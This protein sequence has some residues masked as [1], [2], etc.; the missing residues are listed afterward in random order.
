MTEKDEK[1]SAAWPQFLVAKRAM[2]DAY[3]RATAHSKDQVVQTH[4][5]VV[6]EASVRDWLESFLPKRYGVTSGFIRAQGLPAPYQSSHFDVI[7]YDQLEAPILW[8]EDNKDKSNSGRT[9]II[10]AEFALAVLEVKSAFNRRTVREAIAKLEELKPLT[11]GF[12]D[13]TY[14]RFLPNQA[15]LSMLFFEL[16]KADQFDIEPLNL[17]RDARF[18][19]AFYNPVILRGE[20]RNSDDTALIQKLVG[21]ETLSPLWPDYGLLHGVAGS[22]SIEVEGHHFSAMLLWADVNFATFA[23]D[24]LALLKG[25]YRAGYGSSFHGLEIRG[26]LPTTPVNKPE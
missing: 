2:L 21:T 22:G 19:R 16:R 25:T 18:R 15:I 10:P 3:D 5:G 8:I 12:N 11:S 9:R 17:I 7:I 24:P 1:Y 14:P 20:G 4:H 23:F 13:G 6:G 26:T